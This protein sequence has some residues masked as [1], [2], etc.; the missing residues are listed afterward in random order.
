MYVYAT[1]FE[2]VDLV[3]TVA[4]FLRKIFLNFTD[5]RRISFMEE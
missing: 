5:L 4:V 2:I 1:K 3:T